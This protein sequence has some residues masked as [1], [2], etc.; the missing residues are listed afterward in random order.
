MRMLSLSPS[1][2]TYLISWL[3]W[4]IDNDSCSFHLKIHIKTIANIGLR[5]SRPPSGP[6]GPRIG[7]K[8][9]TFSWWRVSSVAHSGSIWHHKKEE[10]S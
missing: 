8:A 6:V 1:K 5:P 7:K 4:Y 10:K 2:L 3:V 9:L